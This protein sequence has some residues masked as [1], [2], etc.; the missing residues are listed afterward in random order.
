MAMF[1]TESALAKEMEKQ[2]ARKECKLEDGTTVSNLEGIC[3]SFIGRALNGD[4]SAADFI[5]K[6]NEGKKK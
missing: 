1:D 4:L 2:L 5:V 6:L 3:Q